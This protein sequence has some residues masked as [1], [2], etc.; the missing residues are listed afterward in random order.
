M[1]YI[2]YISGSTSFSHVHNPVAD[3]YIPSNRVSTAALSV[4]NIILLLKGLRTLR[5]AN[6]IDRDVL[7]STIVVDVLS[8]Q[9]L[10]VTVVIKYDL[11]PGVF[12]V[13]MYLYLP[14]RLAAVADSPDLFVYTCTQSSQPARTSCDPRGQLQLQLFVSRSLLSFTYD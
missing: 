13:E 4:Y 3:W 9:N 2:T 6:S 1:L 11:F 12:S 5:A 10:Q 8:F 7:I 14:Q